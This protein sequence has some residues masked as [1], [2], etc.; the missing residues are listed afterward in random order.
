MIEALL[1]VLSLRGEMLGMMHI[2][3]SPKIFSSVKDC[4]DWFDTGEGV[5]TIADL[6]KSLNDVYPMPIKVLPACF[7]PNQ[8]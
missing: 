8:A 1:V 5:K 7:A 4:R 2:G 3:E 6:G